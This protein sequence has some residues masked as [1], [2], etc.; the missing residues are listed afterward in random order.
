MTTPLEDQTSGKYEDSYLNVSH[1]ELQPSWGKVRLG[2][3]TISVAFNSS[4]HLSLL[5]LIIGLT[6]VV[7]KIDQNTHWKQC[8]KIR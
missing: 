2:K 8:Y 5:S 4:L 1:L 7:V 3:A 6:R